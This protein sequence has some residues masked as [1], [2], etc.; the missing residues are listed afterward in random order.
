MYVF[1]IVGM[2]ESENEE[3]K[4]CSGVIS[5]HLAGVYSISVYALLRAMQRLMVWLVLE[6]FFVQTV[7]TGQFI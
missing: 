6:H 7:Q 5:E 1:S 4:M 3:Q 2:Y